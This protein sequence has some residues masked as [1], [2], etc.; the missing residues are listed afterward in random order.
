MS[1]T[2]YHFDPM[3]PLT[4]EVGV[5]TINKEIGRCMFY[6]KFDYKL[7]SRTL[8]PPESMIFRFINE[9][10]EHADIVNSPF[11][12]SWNETVFLLESLVVRVPTFDWKKMILPYEITLNDMVLLI[13]RFHIYDASNEIVWLRDEPHMVKACVHKFVNKVLEANIIQHEY[14]HL[15]TKSDPMIL[16]DYLK[17][18][19][20]ESEKETAEMQAANGEVQQ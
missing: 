18:L 2:L 15:D 11:W 4:L 3:C 12:Y 14:E 17:M 19:K 5:E 9:H 1:H 13:R 8:N 7:E 20:E 16:E 6:P 10:M